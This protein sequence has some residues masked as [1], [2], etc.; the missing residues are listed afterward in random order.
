[1]LIR[2]Q[3][4]EQSVSLLPFGARLQLS[5]AWTDRPTCDFLKRGRAPP[6]RPLTALAME[7]TARSKFRAKASHSGALARARKAAH[8]LSPLRGGNK[9]NSI[10]AAERSP[11]RAWAHPP[12][13]K[14]VELQGE[15]A[16][17]AAVKAGMPV[18]P[19]GA[20]LSLY[21]PGSDEW[22][23]AEIMSY[24][25]LI[26][27]GFVVQFKHQ[28]EYEMGSFFHDLLDMEYTTIELP[29]PP[30]EALVKVLSQKNVEV[31]LKQASH[32]H[33]LRPRGL[34]KIDLGKA[35]NVYSANIELSSSADSLPPLSARLRESHDM[36]CARAP[37]TAHTQIGRPCWI[38]V[39]ASVRED[40]TK[41]P[42]PLLAACA[43]QTRNLAAR[44]L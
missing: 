25:A 23:E 4:A 21:W 41:R 28:C 22:F 12:G 15:V 16:R 6:L 27:D 13:G 26:D 8:S 14:G 20:R 35:T 36:E 7:G 17:E 30:P 39:C 32:E 2:A 10:Q 43:G 29:A 42:P 34:S 11:L 37:S 44:A 38:V 9:E 31:N 3:S 24:C 18:V 5:S 19:I 1:M 33:N 40:D